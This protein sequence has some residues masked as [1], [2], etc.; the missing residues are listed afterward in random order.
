M[1]HSRTLAVLALAVVTVAAPAAAAQQQR[2]EELH[3]MVPAT[4]D[5]TRAVALSD[6]D[7]DGDLDAFLANH[8]EPNR[9][10]LN[11]GSGHYSDGSER[12]PSDADPSLGV[13]LADLDG[14]GDVDV[15]IANGESG[16]DRFYRNDGASG[17]SDQTQALP[18]DADDTRAVALLDAD[19]D[20]DLDAMFANS[21]AQNRY[22]RNTGAGGFT[23][24]TSLIP[25][26]VFDS[27]AL[28]TGD[29]D[30]DGDADV[31]IANSSGQPNLLFENDGT[32]S[33]VLAA[34]FPAT[35]TDS[36]AVVLC[37]FDA[38]L[39]PDLAFGNDGDD[40]L[41]RNDPPGTFTVVAGALGP[42]VVDTLGMAVGDL[43]GDGLEDL[44]LTSKHSDLFFLSTGSDLVIAGTL[45]T[46]FS[47]TAALAL[48]D[49]DG[50]QDLDA[51]VAKPNEPLG[52]N[53]LCLNDGSA[54]FVNVTR[55]ELY[56]YW[57]GSGFAE[58][59]DLDGDQDLDLI[60]GSWY[61]AQTFAYLNDGSGKYE[62]GDMLYPPS[63]DMS[64]SELADVDGDGDLDAVI[65]SFGTDSLWFNDGLATFDQTSDLPGAG[66]WGLEAGDL[67]GDGD[68]DLFRADNGWNGVD[69]NDSTG[70]FVEA[71]GAL[72]LIASHSRDLAL[73][74]VD[75]D[76]DLDAFVPNPYNQDVL[77]VNDGTATFS[78]A[79]ASLPVDAEDSQVVR[80]A[81]VDG[82][83]DIDA[84]IGTGQ[85][86]NR[87]YRNDGAGSFTDST[88][89]LPLDTDYT[90]S[91]DVGDVDGDGDV[92][93]VFGNF[94][95][96]H[97]S[98][99]SKNR[100]LRNDGGGVFSDASASLPGY[101][102][103]AGEVVLFDADGDADLDLYVANRGVH[104]LFHNVGRQL[105]WRTYPRV[106]NDITMDLD[107]PAGA[108]WFLAAGPHP[109]HLPLP[110]FGIMLVD[111]STLVFLTAGTLDGTGQSSATAFVPN[112]PGLIGDSIFWQAFVGTPS[113][114]SSLEVAVLT[115]L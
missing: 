77:Y 89:D 6:L 93:V 74:D 91:M 55:H 70:I 92:D 17:F 8:A 108:A 97:G 67:D 30:L 41:L 49:V 1:N 27:R 110:P 106:D 57:S 75:G 56:A 16:Q 95:S 102:E 15:L 69:L 20:G 48:G 24:A 32:G 98:P 78:D 59:G 7:G 96:V 58:A 60:V 35:A 99:D 42:N 107:G 40:E 101:L 68:V 85:A 64:C 73:G 113:L 104:R 28:A 25:A 94:G 65:G 72:P 80:L 105:S 4:A 114:F 39:D 9:L 33:Y 66:T 45:E 71:V 53:E 10:Y 47:K 22:Y 111:P 31:V 76:G 82:D 38:D 86:Q 44:A 79:S 21:G 43:D 12:I 100:L 14:D 26:G 37:D 18:A 5:D 81:D 34:G 19:A 115:D 87:L 36:Q 83:G 51:F 29:L 88:T 112:Q 61:S 52:E 84:L 46:T 90:Y 13:A 62:E 109:A 50:D 23:D 103:Q 54:G 63:A 3:R 2:F 11:D